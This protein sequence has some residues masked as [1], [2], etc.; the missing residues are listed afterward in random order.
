M[1]IRIEY[2]YCRTQPGLISNPRHNGLAFVTLDRDISN[3]TEL[4]TALKKWASE[5]EGRGTIAIIEV[6]KCGEIDEK[7]EKM[8]EH[9]RGA[10]MEF[11][12]GSAVLRRATLAA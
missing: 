1:E 4:R 6:C 5:W 7:F 2:K 9:V 3:V 10:A 12:D 11:D 8:A